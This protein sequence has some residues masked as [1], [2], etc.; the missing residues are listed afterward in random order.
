[1]RRLLPIIA[2]VLAAC[3]EPAVPLPAI[4]AGVDAGPFRCTPLTCAGCCRNNIC[5]GGN[6]DEACGYDGR[7]CQGCP[8]GTAC[9]AP[10]ACISVPRDGG[11]SAGAGT[12]DPGPLN[13]LTGLPLDDG[14]RLRC[15]VRFGRL[16]C[17]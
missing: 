2:V 17:L 13:P 8:E 10:G 6:D 11:G 14:L 4:D 16:V 5:R 15:F 12:P 1:M 9:Q 3:V 7:L